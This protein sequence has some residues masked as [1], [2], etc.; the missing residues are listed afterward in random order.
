MKFKKTFV[1]SV[2]DSTF[3]LLLK[4]ICVVLAKCT[5]SYGLNNII[6]LTLSLLLKSIPYH[7]PY[8]H[9]KYIDYDNFQT[10]NYQVSICIEVS[11]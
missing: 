2:T 1:S 5:I 6:M 9:G 8:S 7:C 3:Y 11:F 10:M 4:L